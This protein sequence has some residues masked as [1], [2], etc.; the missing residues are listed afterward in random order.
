MECTRDL[1]CHNWHLA[2]GM[3]CKLLKKVKYSLLFVSGK[4]Q[5]YHMNVC[6]FSQWLTVKSAATEDQVRRSFLSEHELFKI[7]KRT[8][9]A[10]LFVIDVVRDSYFVHRE[11]SADYTA[12]KIYSG[13]SMSHALSVGISLAKLVRLGAENYSFKQT[14]RESICIYIYIYI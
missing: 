2:Q 3:Q 6:V 7:L 11:A 13:R 4:M 1:H 12:L 14:Q 9:L 8:F 5:C 10:C